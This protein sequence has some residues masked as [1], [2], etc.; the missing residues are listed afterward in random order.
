MKAIIYNT[1]L[2]F[3]FISFACSQ[4]NKQETTTKTSTPKPLDTFSTS[5]EV[6][7]FKS[8]GITAIYTSYVKLRDALVKTDIETTKKYALE[9][10]VAFENENKL[11]E[12]NITSTINETTDI[13]IAREAFFNLNESLGPI[14]QKDMISG[15]INMCFCPMA[16]DN[17]GAS[18]FTTDDEIR[19]PYFGDRML[20]CGSIQETLVAK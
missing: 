12:A 14:L 8:M 19:N 16:R 4:Q 15:Q 18:W 20:K 5:Q 1:I 13:G 6:L 17:Q 9:L 2:S 10:K 11:L 3:I 7:Q